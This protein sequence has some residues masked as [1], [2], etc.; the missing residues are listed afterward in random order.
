M[1]GL[2]RLLH[3]SGNQ[4]YHA[5]LGTRDSLEDLTLHKLGEAGDMKGVLGSEEE[6]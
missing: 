1:L 3:W 4:S 5:D 2:A 6:Q